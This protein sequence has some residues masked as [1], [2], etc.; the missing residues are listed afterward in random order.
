ML[1]SL[2]I[3]VNDFFVHR[4]QPVIRIYLDDLQVLIKRPREFR[5]GDELLHQ[6]IQFSQRNLLPVPCHQN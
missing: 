2:F 6:F 5:I 3:E 1:W 4:K